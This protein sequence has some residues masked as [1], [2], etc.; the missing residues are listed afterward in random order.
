MAIALSS[1]LKRRL[2]EA[3]SCAAGIYEDW[4]GKVDKA[5]KFVVLK[6][7]VLMADVDPHRSRCC[8]STREP[9]SP[10]PRSLCLTEHT[11]PAASTSSSLMSMR[12][13]VACVSPVSPVHRL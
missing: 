8:L 11:R 4:T 5:I 6:A 10:R 13:C 7:P 2:E 3:S 9:W 12:L 1:S